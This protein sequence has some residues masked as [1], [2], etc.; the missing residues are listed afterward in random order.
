MSP[1]FGIPWFTTSGLR[2]DWLHCCDQGVASVFLGGLFHMVLCDRAYGNNEDTRCAQLWTAIQTFYAQHQT[3]DRLN[4]LT[5]FMK[6][7][8][9][10]I[11]LSGSAAEVRCLVPFGKLL[12]DSWEDPLG[13]ESFA[14]KTCMKHLARC[15]EFLQ[16]TLQAQQD[17]LLD[18]ALAFHANLLLLKEFNGKRWQVRPKLHMFLELCLEGGTPSSSWPNYREES[19]GG[20][21]SHQGHRRGGFST[22]L[23]M[24]RSVLTKFCAKASLPR[25]R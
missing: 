10:S 15:Y 7:K 20:S 8:S 19:F 24:S 18:N 23:A 22:P 11:E 6:P 17:T 2:I 14:A 4:N 13:P 3:K 9:G 5:V 21:V 25:M 12:V 16:P 1:A